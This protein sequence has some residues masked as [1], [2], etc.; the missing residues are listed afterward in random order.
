MKKDKTKLHSTEN[1]IPLLT[2]PLTHIHKK[3]IQGDLVF[4]HGLI[5]TK[6]YKRPY[7]VTQKI[8]AD[9]WIE[10]SIALLHNNSFLL[11]VW[12]QGKTPSC[13]AVQKIRGKKRKRNRLIKV[14]KTLI[15]CWQ[16]LQSVSKLSK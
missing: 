14:I 2:T 9:N 11:F 12:F 6:M 13:S 7:D 15:T 3:Q 1:D 8:P 4:A 16:K 5:Y 10:A